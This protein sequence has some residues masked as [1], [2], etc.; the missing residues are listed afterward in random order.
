MG[1]RNKEQDPAENLNGVANRDIIQRINF[2]Y[3]AS[4]YLNSISQALPPG[5]EDVVTLP[6][7]VKRKDT[8]KKRKPQIRHPK[9]TAEL[10]RS[11]I[12]TM[13][14]IGQKTMVRM[15]P[16]LKRTL[17]KGC[18]TVLLP[19]LTATVRVRPLP[20]HGEAV[21]HTCLTCRTTRRIPAPP[22]L[23]SESPLPDSRPA[24]V[25]TES[26]AA[27]STS[28]VATEA[29]A[30]MGAAIDLESRNAIHRSGKRTV[31]RFPPLF[32]RKG[33]VVFRGNER[34]PEDDEPTAA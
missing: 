19:G 6:Q 13:R 22:V 23:V 24:S 7:T 32:E 28:A 27:T 14:I 10:S 25:G 33:H 34:L 21:Y 30:T 9:N 29:R 1:K 3:Q 12:G 4:T 26:V 15:D 2:L 18:D 20:S 31:P 8:L 5:A 17:C 11:Y 16:T